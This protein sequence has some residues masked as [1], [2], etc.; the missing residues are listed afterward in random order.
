MDLERIGSFCR[1]RGILFCVDAIQSIGALCFDVQGIG[2]DCVMADGHK[3]M[4]GPEG[5][6]IMY[7][8]D[9]LRERLKLHQFGWH[10]VEAMGDFDRTDWSIA[11]SARRFE[12]GSPNMLGIHGLS[13]SLSLLHEVGMD[14]IEQDVLRRAAYCMERISSFH[15]LE[16][17]TPSQTGRYGGIVTFRSINAPAEKL[18][19]HLMSRKILC[20]PRSGGVR[21]SPHF[22]TSFD[23]I[24]R[25]LEEAAAFHHDHAKEN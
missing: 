6:A 7:V 24:D 25:A 4:L 18:Y 13:A 17:I 3:W 2:A 19:S 15:Q 11:R 1:D 9:R 22:Y 20:A 23:R 21:F 10:M 5:L 8:R 14:R 12:C 16:L